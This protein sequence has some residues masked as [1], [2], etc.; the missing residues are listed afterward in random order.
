MEEPMVFKGEK[1]IVNGKETLEVK[2]IAE[3]KEYPD[4]RR[5]VTMHMPTLGIIAATKKLHGIK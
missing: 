5:D 2:P 3:V 4:G 1:K